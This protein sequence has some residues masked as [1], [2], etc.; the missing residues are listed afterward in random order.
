MLWGIW[1]TT[2]VK[3]D[4]QTIQFRVAV[5][6]LCARGRDRKKGY[7]YSSTMGIENAYPLMMAHLSLSLCKTYTQYWARGVAM[8]NR[9]SSSLRILPLLLL[10]LPLLLLLEVQLEVVQLAP[11]D[12]T[13]MVERPLNSQHKHSWLV[14]VTVT[15]SNCNQHKTATITRNPQSRPRAPLSRI[16]RRK[17]PQKNSFAR[18][19]GTKFNTSSILSFEVVRLSLLKSSPLEEGAELS[20]Q[21]AQ[22]LIMRPLEAP[23]RSEVYCGPDG[24]SVLPLCVHKL[25]I[26]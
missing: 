4:S 9:P 25:Y 1:K 12:T 16:R 14:I 24:I 6:T 10:A 11:L 21:H 8:K 3:T 20:S 22:W 13:G 2:S 26:C 7:R 18:E 15:V 5:L 17:T 23:W 19:S